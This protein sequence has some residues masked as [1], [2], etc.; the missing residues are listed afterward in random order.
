M[1]VRVKMNILFFIFT[2]SSHLVFLASWDLQVLK[3]THSSFLQITAH[4]VIFC[5]EDSPHCSSHD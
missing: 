5:V 1:V 4:L 2:I 3:V